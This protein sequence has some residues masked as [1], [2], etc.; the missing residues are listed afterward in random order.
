MDSLK[1]DVEVLC[2]TNRSL[3]R[4]YGLHATE[5]RPQQQVGKVTLAHHV[6]RR[7]E[8]RAR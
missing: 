2:A 4:E 3:V 1:G 8:G 5:S 6:G 7:V